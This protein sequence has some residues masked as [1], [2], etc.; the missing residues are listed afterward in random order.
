LSCKHKLLV[1]QKHP[2]INVS[3][4][5]GRQNKGKHLSLQGSELQA[6]LRVQ[7]FRAVF[8]SLLNTLYLRQPFFGRVVFFF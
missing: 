4:K 2:P 1:D 3:V 5:G 8:L 6:V 7:S